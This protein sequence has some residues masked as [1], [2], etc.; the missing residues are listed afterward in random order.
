MIIYLERLLPAASSDP[1]GNESGQLICSL[2]GLASDGVYM[3][4]VVTN[5]TVVSYTA[6]PPLPS[7]FL[8]K[9]TPLASQATVKTA[10]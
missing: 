2:F 4:T 10:L 8:T 5:N 3:A 6:F 7:D 1:P 9:V